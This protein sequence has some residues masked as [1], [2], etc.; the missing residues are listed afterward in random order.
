MPM[1]MKSLSGASKR[2]KTNQWKKRLEKSKEVDGGPRIFPM[3]LWTEKRNPGN[4][5]WLMLLQRFG[6]QRCSFGRK[7]VRFGRPFP[8]RIGSHF[9]NTDLVYLR[10]WYAPMTKEPISKQ[11][12]EPKRNVLLIAIA[13][14]IPIPIPSPLRS[15]S[16]KNSI[17]FPWVAFLLI[18]PAVVFFF[19]ST[20]PDFPFYFCVSL[21]RHSPTHFHF[22]FQRPQANER[23]CIFQIKMQPGDCLHFIFNF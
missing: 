15:A 22:H 21:L 23:L 19:F 1:R 6:H 7:V 5:D 17:Y 11:Q 3:N 20:M 10:P 18:C 12:Q 9:G 4:I 13:I 8:I 14:P 2:N 16:K